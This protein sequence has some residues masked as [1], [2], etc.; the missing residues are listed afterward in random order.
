MQESADCLQT[1]GL[2]VKCS[3]TSTTCRHTVVTRRDDGLPRNGDV[4]SKL[5]VLTFDLRL[6]R[7]RLPTWR[8]AQVL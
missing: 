4:S 7:L 2:T 5:D 3:H 8:N 1:R 6:R